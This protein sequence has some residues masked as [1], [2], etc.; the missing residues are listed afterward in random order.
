[1][2]SLSSLA[3][4]NSCT[5]LKCIYADFYNLYHCISSQVHY[6]PHSVSVH[7]LSP[8]V[9]RKLWRGFLKWKSQQSRV[10][11]ISFLDSVGE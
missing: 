11:I 3:P 5:G 8:H 7:P 9:W 4:S 6:W 2:V 1:M 10:N